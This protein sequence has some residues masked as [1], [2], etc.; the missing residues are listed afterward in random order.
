M[1]W[2]CRCLDPKA[3]CHLYAKTAGTKSWANCYNSPTKELQGVVMT[4]IMAKMEQGKGGPS[5]KTSVRKIMTVHLLCIF[6][7][8]LFFFFF[9]PSV[10]DVFLWT[11]ELCLRLFI[12]CC[13]NDF[14]EKLWD[15]L[16]VSQCLETHPRLLFY[17]IGPEI[18]KTLPAR[19]RP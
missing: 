6:L 3:H 1:H 17:L 16:K 18:Y 4:I 2:V 12:I 19:L 7:C 13:K 11:I 9:F 14:H 10:T 8:V 5:A 15:Y